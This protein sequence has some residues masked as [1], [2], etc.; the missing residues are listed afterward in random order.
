MTAPPTMQDVLLRLAGYW[1]GQGCVLLQPMNTE[2]GAGT[3][4]PGTALRIL[5][6]EPWRTAYVEPSV[7]PADAR[8]GD[9]PNR[10]QTFT[11]YQVVLKPD[12]GDPQDRYL[13]SLAAIGIDI[14]RHDVRFIEDNWTAPPLGAWGLGWEVWLDGLEIT[15]FTYFQQSGGLPLDPVAVEI[16]YGIE[17]IVMALQG[18]SHF[19][20][21]VYAPGSGNRTEGRGAVSASDGSMPSVRF[22][23]G[24]TYGE[25]FGQA[26]L[27]M[28]RY[29]LDEADVAANRMLFDIYE[30]EARR[31]TGERLPVPAHTSIL[32][33]SHVFNV[34]D[35]RG[36]VGATERAQIFARLRALAQDVA[37]LWVERRAELGF[38]LGVATAPAPPAT[39]P[40]PE[41]ESPAPLAFEI[42][43]EELPAAEVGRAPDMVRTALSERLGAT[44]LGHGPIRVAASPRRVVACIDRVEPREE[45][46]TERVRGPRVA[47]AFD[48][49]GRPTAAALGFARRHGVS[50]DQLE[51]LEANGEQFVSVLR[52]VQGRSAAEV[53]AT[54]LP[55]IVE[56][57]R[58]ERNMRW[59]APGLTYSRPIRWILALLGTEV[60]PFAVSNLSSGRTTFVHRHAPQPAIQVRDAAGYLDTLRAHGIIAGSDN[61]RTAVLEQAAALAASAGGAIDPSGDGAVIDEV[62]DI[63]EEPLAIL[64]SFDAAYLDL[65]HDVLTTVMK[66]HQRYLPV[67]DPDGR[68]LPHFVAVANGPC[69]RELVRGGNEAVLRARYEDAAFFFAHDLRLPPEEMKRGLAGLLFESRLGSMADRAARIGAVAAELA[70]SVSLEG[71]E[72]A[73][74]ARAGELARFDLASRMVIELPSLAGAMAREYARRAGEP[75]AVA[76]ALFELELPRFSGDALPTTLPGALLALADRL[77]LLAGLFAI[78]AEPTGSSDPFGLRRAAV[79]V[80]AILSSQPRLGGITLEAGLAVAAG[81]QPVAAGPEAIGEARRFIVRRL[82]QQLLD[83]GHAVR[84]VRAV[85]PLASRPSRAE[86]AAGEVGRLLDDP[87]FQAVSGAMLRVRRIVPPGTSPGYDEARFETAAEREL[88]G[89]L[90]EV[91]A[92]LAPDGQSVARFTTIAAR[93]AAPIDRFFDDVLVMAPDP[94]VRANRL[95]L[96]ASV[97]ELGAGLLDWDELE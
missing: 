58:G 61:R 60:V 69:D 91:A 28:S 95:G 24:V 38:P 96:L 54:I 80:T 72:R 41:I 23:S 48:A 85:L 22:P 42:G 15:Q 45:D 6:P 82:E 70:G 27:E 93:L 19:K 14:A 75:E 71:E 84:V 97:S 90:G 4:N 62:V 2:V 43:V 79:G 49:G 34:L 73:T 39:G 12:P 36:A 81:K 29:Y 51:R 32:K 66:K 21:I 86:L 76:Q 50:P 30:Q 77:D 88:H 33:C 3:W 74:L 10:L 57:L 25:V 40:L 35:A 67:R 64:G 26:E 46:I 17:R 18:V 55:A 92:E 53:L 1:A 20:D 78:G 89:V 65:P 52:Q 59:S 9:N 8:Y 13:D 87:V 83:A 31:L 7:R 16:T 37:R 94:A 44:R 11:Q 63:V 47:A 5:G 56:G 68:L